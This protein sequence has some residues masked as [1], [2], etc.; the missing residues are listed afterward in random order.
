VHLVAFQ[1]QVQPQPLG[2]LRR[3]AD[4]HGATV[5]AFVVQRHEHTVSV[6]HCFLSILWWH[7]VVTSH[8]YSTLCSRDKAM[9]Q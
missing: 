9:S 6:P 1:L 7:A 5:R 4:L 8:A 3:K 2:E